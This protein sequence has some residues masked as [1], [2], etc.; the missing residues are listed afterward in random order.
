MYELSISTGDTNHQYFRAD[1]P[2]YHSSSAA[3]KAHV[4]EICIKALGFKVSGDMLV[5]EGEVISSALMS[6][7]NRKKCIRFAM[8]LME[9]KVM[10]VVT[11]SV[12]CSSTHNSCLASVSL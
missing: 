8:K 6:N 9:S 5:P 11:P 10:I 2:V 12:S 4:A 7:T 3:A 1:P